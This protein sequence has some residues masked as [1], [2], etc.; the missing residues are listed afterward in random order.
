[1]I[2]HIGYGVMLG[3]VGTPLFVLFLIT[4]P[5]VTIFLTLSGKMGLLHMV[6]S[7]CVV[8]AEMIYTVHGLLSMGLNT[9]VV[10]SAVV[11]TIVT[12]A[13]G[14]IFLIKDVERAL[15]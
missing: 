10:T 14:M 8:V 2:S 6:I 3:V 4:A 7:G 5:Y 15:T 1:M 13:I 12:T 9:A 11:T